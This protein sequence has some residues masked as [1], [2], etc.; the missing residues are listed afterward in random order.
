M[1]TVFVGPKRKVFHLHRDLLCD[2]SAYFKA[3][4]LGSFK[5]AETQEL[6]LADDDVAAFEIFVN[7]L[8]GAG[9]KTPK[10]DE[11][12]S[13]CLALFAL[14]DRF[15]LEHLKHQCVDSIRGYY[16]E[17]GAIV[18][19][20]D[21][22]YAY[23]HINA[24]K[25]RYCLVS[26]AV[27]QTNERSSGQMSDTHLPGFPELISES[28]DFPVLFSRFLVSFLKHPNTAMELLQSKHNCL[29]HTHDSTP[30]CKE[31]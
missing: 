12:L 28:G 6:F 13:T 26:L 27:A 19:A 4:L 8:Y 9:V 29:Y 3:T 2:R 17:T 10:K 16:R 11:E 25:V 14:A 18:R 24:H 31:T 7:C 22:A 5:E 15:F 20:E 30:K 23:E 21:F 1:V